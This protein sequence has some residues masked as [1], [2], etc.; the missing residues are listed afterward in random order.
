MTTGR[1]HAQNIV[2]TGF[3][4]TGK[5]TVGRLVADRLGLAFVDTDAIIEARDGRTIADIFAQDG[6]AAFRQLEADVCL[7]TASQ[8]GQVIATGGGAL[9]NPVVRET[10]EASGLVICLKCGLDEAIRRVGDDPARPLFAT[11]RDRLARLLAARADLYDSL[12][13]QIDTTHHSPP[14][15]VEEVLRLWYM[16]IT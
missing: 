11:E 8:R 10:F 2:L 4:G 3:M 16:Q 1:K 13:H 6:E 15:I 7:Q 9:L 5:S 14:E 12:P